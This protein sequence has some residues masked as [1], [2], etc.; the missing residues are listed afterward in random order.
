MDPP[1]FHKSQNNMIR[2]EEKIRR[3]LAKDL[4]GVRE[5]TRIVDEEVDATATVKGDGSGEV[6]TKQPPA[7]CAESYVA[8]ATSRHLYFKVLG[9]HSS[10]QNI[11]VTCF[12]P[13]ISRP[14]A[15]PASKP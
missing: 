5:V 11:N 3:R 9:I 13:C 7:G 6:T 10:V 15:S 8:P 2:D 14:D 4:K 1:S 12:S